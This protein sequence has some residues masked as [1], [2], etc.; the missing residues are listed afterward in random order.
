MTETGAGAPHAGAPRPPGE[1]DEAA[2]C[3]ALAVQ[4]ARWYADPRVGAVF[5]YTFREDDLFPVGLADA[6]LTRL[7]PAYYLWLAWAQHGTADGRAAP[8]GAVRIG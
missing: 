2:G 1:A 8:A 3:R 7:Y 5:Q 6:A 4:L